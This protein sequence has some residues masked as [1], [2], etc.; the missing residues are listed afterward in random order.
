MAHRIRSKEGG[1]GISRTEASVRVLLLSLGCFLVLMPVAWTV[2]TSLKTAQQ[3]LEVP[4]VWFF[5][6]QWSNYAEVLTL[7]PFQNYALNTAIIVTSVVVGTL[8][9]CSFSAYGFARLRAPGRNA[10]FGVLMA[11]MMLPATVTLVP[12]YIAFNKIGW[13]NTFLPLIVPAFFGSAFFIFMFRQFYL[14]LPREL[15]E[16]A[17]IDG[18]GYFRIWWSIFLPLSMPVIATVTVF[19]FVGTY[20]DFFGPLIYLTDE[21]KWTIS[22]ALSSFGGSP[23]IGPQL[24]MLTAATMIAAAPSIIVFLLAQRYYVNG[25]SVSGINK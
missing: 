8:L 22:V 18:A 6:P 16:A 5:D 4:P 23:R 9:S 10:I 25:I 15:E 20:N 7:V 3:T 1:V 24:H 19:T 14:S 11:T 13:I 2:L 17:R 21:S 12:T